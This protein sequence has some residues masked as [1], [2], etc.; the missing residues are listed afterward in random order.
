EVAEDAPDWKLAL[1]GSDNYGEQAKL[2]AIVAERGLS[3]RVVFPGFVSGDE[4]LA[5]LK[6]AGIFCLPSSGEGL[7]ISQLEAMAC[8]VPCLLSTGCNYPEI[9]QSGGG[10][11]LPLEQSA[12]AKHLA[13]LMNDESQRAA[14]GENARRQFE[15]HHTLDAVGRQFEAAYDQFMPMA[16][17]I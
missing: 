8:G 11:E 10:F 12:W 16:S 6:H 7:S 5:W 9:Q 2:E 15:K 1:V 17:R 14:C 4:K 3:E 13:M